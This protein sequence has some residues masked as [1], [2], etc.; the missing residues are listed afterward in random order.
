MSTIKYMTRKQAGDV[1][2]VTKNKRI[3]THELKKY[4]RTSG[5]VYGDFQHNLHFLFFFFNKSI[6]VV[7]FANAEMVF[8]SLASFRFKI[9]ST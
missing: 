2:V 5:Y 3:T 9:L 1:C 6:R 7:T 4:S 8:P